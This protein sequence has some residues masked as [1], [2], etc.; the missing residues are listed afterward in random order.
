MLAS[1]N[2]KKLFSTILVLSFLFS[3]NAYSKD[4]KSVSWTNSSNAAFS[5]CWWILNF[6][7]TTQTPVNTDVTSVSINSFISVYNKNNELIKK[8]KVK[9]IEYS[10]GRC[11]ITPQPIRRY[12][13]YFTTGKC[14]ING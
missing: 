13:T 2:M 14:F 11:W 4:V 10:S 8:F 12:K 1:W 5:S 3:G 9:K 7:C 6:I